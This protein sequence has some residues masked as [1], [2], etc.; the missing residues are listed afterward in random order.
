MRN[1][2]IGTRLGVVFALAITLFVATIINA[3]SE[4]A[5][6]RES[7]NHISKGNIGKIRLITQA[8]NSI[9]EITRSIGLIASIE[10][11]Y[12]R[13]TSREN[14]EKERT[15]YREVMV[16][17]DKTPVAA[18]PAGKIYK[19]CLATFKDA[20]KEDSALNDQVMDAAMSGNQAESLRVLKISIPYIVKVNAASAALLKSQY[21][22]ADGRIKKDVVKALNS[23]Q[24]WMVSIVILVIAISILAAFWITKSITGPVNLLKE[25]LQEIANGDGDLTKR[26]EVN[27]R[28]EIGQVAALFN[29]FV[30]KLHTSISNVTKN[31]HEMS[32]AAIQLHATAKGIASESENAVARVNTVATAGEE[33]SATS[34]DIARSCSMVSDGARQASQSAIEGAGV[35]NDTIAVMNHIAVRVQESAKAVENLGSRSEQIGEIVG[36]I[37]EI[38]DQTN[39]LALNAA[40]EAAR[41]GEQGRGFAVVADEVRA[42]AERTS[43]ATQEIS[44]MIKTIQNETKDAVM[45]MNQGVKDVTTGSEKAALS[46]QALEHILAQINAVTMQISQ[47]AT[48]AEEQTATTAEISNNMHEINDVINQASKG[49]HESAVAANQ[50][51]CTSEALKISVSQFKL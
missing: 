38:A 1:L 12:F 4:F 44:V 17:L 21:D 49:A 42:L 39:L 9:G 29:Q 3:S 26:L 24:N 10:D 41:A 18:T 35:V 6:I 27:S 16:E 15:N 11:P 50:L 20:I 48:A 36:T 31:S 37:E 5:K 25:M 14:I 47:V 13:K 32:A 30:D 40:I 46:G 23:A 22:A 34:I 2:N 33:I 8:V 28:D 7:G 19:D 43:R 45:A 51:A